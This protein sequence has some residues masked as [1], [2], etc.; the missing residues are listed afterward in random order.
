MSWLSNPL[1]KNFSQGLTL[2]VAVVPALPAL[3]VLA[4]KKLVEVFKVLL[5]LNCVK[6]VLG[7]RGP[8]TFPVE[9]PDAPPDTPPP[10]A[11]LRIGRFPVTAA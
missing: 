3:D 8:R 7:G 9:P 5:E 1:R 2:V 6:L 10:P 4:V 11:T